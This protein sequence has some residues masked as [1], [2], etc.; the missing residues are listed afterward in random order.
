MCFVSEACFVS[1]ITVMSDI[2]LGTDAIHV[3]KVASYARSVCENEAQEQTCGKLSTS[4]SLF[5]IDRRAYCF[6]IVAKGHLQV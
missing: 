5:V 4:F 6:L 2:E 1:D 3:S